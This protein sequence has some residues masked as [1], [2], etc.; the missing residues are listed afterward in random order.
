[1]SPDRAEKWLE[2]KELT[3]VLFPHAFFIARKRDGFIQLYSVVDENVH[4]AESLALVIKHFE[5][6]A[7]FDQIGEDRWQ[8]KQLVKA[9]GSHYQ[10]L[11]RMTGSFVSMQNM[12]QV[13][14]I[15]AEFAVSE[16]LSGI[17][18]ILIENMDPLCEQIPADYEL[19]EAIA[20]RQILVHRDELSKHVD[21]FLM[22]ERHGVMSHLRYWVCASQAR[23]NGIGRS[24]YRQYL[25]LNA[26]AKRF[27]L[28]VRDD[29]EKAKKIY[30]SYGMRFD[31]LKDTVWLYKK[32]INH[33]KSFGSAE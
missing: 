8:E 21:A 19:A 10:S 9:G 25:R 20:N 26:D 2:H 12:I 13:E 29:N 32:G 4:A 33:E 28:W 17:Q 11:T 22:Y 18:R 14:P 23:G 15:I 1:M 7:V 31:R 5:Q 24:L 30:L 3:G 6:P 16:D 27:I